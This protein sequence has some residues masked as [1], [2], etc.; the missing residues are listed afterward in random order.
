MILEFYL[1][2]TLSQVVR[3]D[4]K[5]VFLKDIILMSTYTLVAT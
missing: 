3:Q 2:L 1:D 4:L 5:I